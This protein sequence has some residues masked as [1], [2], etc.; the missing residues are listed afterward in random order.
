[1]SVRDSIYWKKGFSFSRSQHGRRVAVE[2]Y[3]LLRDY[4]VANRNCRVG[5][6]I[7]IFGRNLRFLSLSQITGGKF[8]FFCDKALYGRPEY[9][10]GELH[11]DEMEG[12]NNDV[13]EVLYLECPIQFQVESKSYWKE[14]TRYSFKNPIIIVVDPAEIIKVEGSS[15]DDFC[16]QFKGFCIDVSFRER[17]AVVGN[18]PANS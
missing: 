4:T 17:I 14:F 11:V 15:L 7:N 6:H 13:A 12:I 1:M 5:S 18:L 2:A 8:D 16:I 3:R 9:S 10:G